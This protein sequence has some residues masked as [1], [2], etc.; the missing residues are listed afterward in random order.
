MDKPGYS[1]PPICIYCGNPLKAFEDTPSIG[2]DDP[3]YLVA[4]VPLHPGCRRTL[5]RER[6]RA[7]AAS[8]PGAV[9]PPSDAS[10]P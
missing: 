4:Y 8:G 7:R 5:L 6:A 10:A 9:G 2:M 3:V 1:Q